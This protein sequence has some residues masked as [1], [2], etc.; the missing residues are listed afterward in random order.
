MHHILGYLTDPVPPGRRIDATAF[1]EKYLKIDHLA[2]ERS[3]L[4][5][6]STFKTNDD[7]KLDIYLIGFFKN[8]DEKSLLQ[9]ILPATNWLFKKTKELVY[10]KPFKCNIG[11]SAELFADFNYHNEIVFDFPNRLFVPIFEWRERSHINSSPL[12]EPN[13][14]RAFLVLHKDTGVLSIFI[15]NAEGSVENVHEFVLTRSE[16]MKN[17]AAWFKIPNL[18]FRPLLPQH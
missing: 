11:N 14:I 15:R 1:R 16:K 10:G 8:A 17:L 4:R 9:E 2:V 5:T 7:M 18:E 13:D 3:D 6:R 12:P